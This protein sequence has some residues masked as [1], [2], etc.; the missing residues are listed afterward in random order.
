MG[1][2]Q[3]LL[4]ILKQKSCEFGEFI[5]SSG[6]K[7]NFYFDAKQTTLHPEGAFLVGRVFFE[8]IRD[9]IPPIEAVGGME[10]GASPIV[11]SIALVSFV[12]GYPINAFIIR[13]EPKSY[14]KSLWIEGKGNLKKG[15]RVV[16]VEDVTTTGATL[17]R[18]IEIAQ[19]EGLT[20]EKAICL[21]DRKE[22]AKEN[23][24]KKG[25]ELETI[26]D[27]SEFITP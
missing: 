23:L 15:T 22:G 17:L 10:L 19:K 5:L 27:I 12:E 4:H 25:F 9:I 8:K 3:R 2:K 24:R 11:T 1:P 16:I 7:S 26:F 6:K 13:K 14:G 18:A 20:V 21:I